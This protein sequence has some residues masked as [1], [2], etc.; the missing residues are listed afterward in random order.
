MV[1]VLCI[2][3]TLLFSFRSLFM[4]TTP[5]LHTPCILSTS[6]FLR[7]ANKMLS[8]SSNFFYS[9]TIR[10][11]CFSNC[12]LFF[13]FVFYSHYLFC[14]CFSNCSLFLFFAF[15]SHY[16]FCMWIN[17]VNKQSLDVC[18]CM[19]HTFVFFATS[20]FKRFLPVCSLLYLWLL[21]NFKFFGQCFFICFSCLWILWLFFVTSVVFLLQLSL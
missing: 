10:F 19:L 7:F 20:V 8:F 11:V 14:I 3:W 1:F 5:A 18:I 9:C 4:L 13:F 2:V 15:Y 16:L 21:K 12:S 6:Y 17:K